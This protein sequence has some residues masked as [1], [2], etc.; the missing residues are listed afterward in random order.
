MPMLHHSSSAAPQQSGEGDKEDH[1]EVSE[2]NNNA[3][4]QIGA[5]QQ[6]GRHVQHME[7]IAESSADS[8][9]SQ[10]DNTTCRQPSYNSVSTA[11]QHTGV[12]A[13]TVSMSTSRTTYYPAPTGSRR[14]GM[15]NDSVQTTANSP[16][17]VLVHQLQQLRLLQQQ[18]REL[19]GT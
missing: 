17:S 1:T 7:S 12:Q 15:D 4:G 13:S 9:N 11:R 19:F 6:Q 10:D 8:D 2:G 14:G 3:A 16:S 18:G 5:R